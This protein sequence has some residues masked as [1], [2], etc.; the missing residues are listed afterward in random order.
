MT[1]PYA[2]ENDAHYREYAN[3]LRL[4]FPGT[5]DGDKRSRR[6]AAP[7]GSRWG[8]GGGSARS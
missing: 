3:E 2:H 4:L 7:F 8:P 1:P 5:D 6:P